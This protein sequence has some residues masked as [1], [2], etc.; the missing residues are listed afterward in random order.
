MAAPTP[1]MMCIDR[2]EIWERQLR[3]RR[4][5]RLSRRR[6]PFGSHRQPGFQGIVQVQRASRASRCRCPNSSGQIETMKRLRAKG[7]ALRAIAEKVTAAATPISPVGVKKALG[8]AEGLSSG[9]EA[10]KARGLVA[11]LRAAVRGE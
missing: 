11:R 8:A 9:H 10:K 4:L 1:I 6:L 5:G 3:G 2:L 7:L